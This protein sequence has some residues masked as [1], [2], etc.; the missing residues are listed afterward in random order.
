MIGRAPMRRRNEFIKNAAILT[1]TSLILRAVGM[2]FRI[3]ISS[4][5]GAEGIGLYQMILSIYVLV[6]GFASSGIVVAVTRMTTDQLAV[7]SHFGAR[8]VLKKC[9]VISVA[10]GLISAAAVAVFAD[11]IGREWISDVR[12]IPSVRVMAL[13]LPF[14]S[15]SCCLRGYFTARRRAGVPSTAQITEQAVRIVISLVLLERLAPV[16]IA[17]SCLAVMLADAISEG[18]GCLHVVLAYFSDSRKLGTKG[19]RLTPP[20]HVYKSIWGITAPIT[21]SHY[22]T[23]LLRTIE[24][25]LVPDCLT[26]YLISRA[27]ALELFGMLRGMAMP[28]ILFPST[29][30]TAF[31]TLLI[32]E[33]SEAQALGKTKGVQSAVRRSLGI[34]FS[35][36]LPIVAIFMIYP[37]ELAV[38]VYDEPEVGWIMRCLAPLMP[39]MY[40]ESVVA[41]I[42]KGL[43]EQMSS[44]R[45]NIA[46]SV[47]RIILTIVL[48]P[49]F[50]MAGF[51]AV[52]VVSNLLTSLLSI[53][54]LMKVA[55]IKF[56]WNAWLL[57]PLVC[58]AIAAAAVIGTERAIDL[59]YVPNLWRIAFGGGIICLIYAV[60][61]LFV[62][63]SFDRILFFTEAIFK[64]PLLKRN[65]KT[66][67]NN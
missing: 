41:G 47:I 63:D 13:S 17:Y 30:L 2:Y 25:I 37:T 21:T 24:S 57:R 27:R 51:L 40:V 31:S 22:L 55:K 20:P 52:M 65:K 11:I 67:L 62:T 64:R 6:S 48:V 4:V 59:S 53:A 1:I 60:I 15:I 36:S 46:D 16:G 50:G 7:G 58:T 9:L 23:T 3:Y 12:S 14:M 49:R 44:L 35:L 43:G 29:L 66:T 28:L 26:R 8:Y 10:M 42:L 56:M 32:P 34:T 19:E 38:L 54:R 39:L 33:L 5:I 18:C 45:Y 61:M